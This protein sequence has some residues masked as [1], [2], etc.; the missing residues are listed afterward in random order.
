MQ[1]DPHAQIDVRSATHPDAEPALD[2]RSMRALELGM[3][4]V[5]FA[6]AALLSLAEPAGAHSMVGTD[7]LAAGAVL[8]IVALVALV[9]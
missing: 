9:R 8:F 5:A 1:S 6:V 3:A 2:Q 4:G 7:L